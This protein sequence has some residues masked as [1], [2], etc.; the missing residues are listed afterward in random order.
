MFCFLFF[1]FQPKNIRID[2]INFKRLTDEEI[3]FKLRS[4]IQLT[5]TDLLNSAIS[6]AS[7]LNVSDEDLIQ[8]LNQY[9]TNDEN[10]RTFLDLI[11]RFISMYKNRLRNNNLTD[12]DEI[13]KNAIRKILNGETTLD[14]DSGKNGVDL[15]KI[16]YIFVSF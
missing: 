7:K 15:R 2:I 4:K 6:R 12:Y 16:Q 10:E 1:I 8:R 3:I 5:F 13:K 11:P 14:W 9:D